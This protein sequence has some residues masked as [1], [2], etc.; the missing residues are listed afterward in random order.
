MESSFDSQLRKKLEGIRPE[1]AG[2][3]FDGER[4]WEKINSGS[5]KRVLPFQAWAT[6]AAAVI[7]GMLIAGYFISRHEN[8][9]TAP[10]STIAENTLVKPETKE[11]VPESKVPPVTQPPLIKTH[12]RQ[13]GVTSSAAD[14]QRGESGSGTG[15]TLVQEQLPAVMQES[16]VQAPPQKKQSGNKVLH[17]TD[18]NNENGAHRY[19]ES[20][21]ESLLARLAGRED[22]KEQ[23]SEMLSALISNYVTNKKFK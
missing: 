8:P 6:H 15:T 1:E 14:P 10:V 21:P 20:K 2:L 4:V 19:A 7:A 23:D 5:R 12:L 16:V 22:A 17:L 18:M 9:V 3:T 11:K 13:S